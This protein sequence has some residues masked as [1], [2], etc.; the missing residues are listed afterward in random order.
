MSDV[1]RPTKDRI[2]VY[3]IMGSVQWGKSRCRP[4]NPAFGCPSRLLVLS[5]AASR[6]QE[7]WGV[8]FDSLP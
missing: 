7:V 6:A 1:P 3:I 5:H 4:G 8:S 2:T